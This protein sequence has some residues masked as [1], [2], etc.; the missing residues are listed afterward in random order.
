MAQI[1]NVSIDKPDSFEVVKCFTNPKNMEQLIR[2]S[3]V[4]PIRT[5][6]MVQR[7]LQQLLTLDLPPQTFDEAVLSAAAVE[8]EGRK[9]AVDVILKAESCLTFGKSPF[10]QF[11]FNRL[12]LARACIY[13]GQS[14]DKMIETVL[15]EQLATVRM[16]LTDTTKNSELRKLCNEQVRD[17]L[18]MGAVEDMSVA[19]VDALLSFVPEASLRSLSIG[20]PCVGKE[21]KQYRVLGLAESKRNEIR[22]VSIHA[23]VGESAQYFFV[24]SYDPLNLERQDVL[25]VPLFE[26][27]PLI[28]M[29]VADTAAAAEASILTEPE[30]LEIVLDILRT[31]SD[32][33]DDPE[34]KLR[35]QTLKTFFIR[36]IFRV[37]DVMKEE[38][39]ETLQQFDLL[40]PLVKLLLTQVSQDKP[41]TEDFD[42]E[43]GLEQ[44]T[45]SSNAL[46]ASLSVLR[47]LIMYSHEQLNAAP[48]TRRVVLEKKGSD[49]TLFLAYEA[50][51]DK[52]TEETP[53]DANACFV[54]K[55]VS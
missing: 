15:Q 51:L 45:Y 20:S 8:R 43:G 42:G 54:F 29:S 34:S 41:K 32:E 1:I 53:P 44:L 10:L 33:K 27:S 2:L 46:E 18:A 52:A 16:L 50:D 55:V 47:N 37:L 26:P 5:Q 36:G 28:D 39:L 31:E 22:D 24:Q 4:A 23:E 17:A 35:L 25:T 11:M 3:V 40:E 6:L 38:Y 49:S 14:Q 48:K 30:I 9:N 21:G 7:I 19:Q 12:Q 13:S